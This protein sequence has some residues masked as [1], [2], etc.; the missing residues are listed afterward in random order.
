VLP[1]KFRLSGMSTA[2]ASM[3]W[4]FNGVNSER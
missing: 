4:I 2:M 1:P 3:P